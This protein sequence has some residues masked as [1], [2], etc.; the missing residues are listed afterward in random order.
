MPK[1]EIPIVAVVEAPN[2]AAALKAQA[3]MKNLLA[4]PMLKMLLQSSGVVLTSYQVGA[5]T[6]KPGGQ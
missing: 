4:N 5:P 1:Y 6:K 3:E 2:D